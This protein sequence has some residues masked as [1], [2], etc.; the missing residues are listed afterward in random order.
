MHRS[1]R[2]F[3]RNK[4]VSEVLNRR[5]GLLDKEFALLAGDGVFNPRS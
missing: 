3:L 4:T 2:E 5:G 1:A